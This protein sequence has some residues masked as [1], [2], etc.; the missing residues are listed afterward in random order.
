MAVCRRRL[1][2]AKSSGISVIFPSAD[3]FPCTIKCMDSVN[4]CRTAHE[5]EMA[6]THNNTLDEP[7]YVG[8]EA[9]VPVHLDRAGP[10][11]VDNVIM[12]SRL[13]I[14]E[15]CEVWD[16]YKSDCNITL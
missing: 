3:H 1:A 5:S 8:V 15:R 2:G 11:H 6:A 13:H 16:L 10:L 12:I 14:N 7:V 9:R 4:F